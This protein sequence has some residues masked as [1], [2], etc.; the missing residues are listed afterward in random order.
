M[1]SDKKRN[2]NLIP[3]KPGQSGNPLG[4]PVG[5]RNKLSE[6]FLNALHEEFQEHG[7]AAVEKVRLERPMEFLKIIAS[8][9]PREM[10]LNINLRDQLAAFLDNMQDITPAPITAFARP[11]HA[12]PDGV[13]R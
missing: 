8:L 1:E 10:N 12:S 9:V 11:R 4:R 2:G 3:W 7:K 6:D 5:A 13:A